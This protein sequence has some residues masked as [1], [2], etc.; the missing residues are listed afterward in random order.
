VKQSRRSKSLIPESPKPGRSDSAEIVDAIVGA[1]VALGDPEVSMNTIA[2]RAG[3]GIASVYRYFPTKDALYTEVARRLQTAFLPQLRATLIRE[4]L[5]LRAV[6]RVCCHHAV[7][8]G[9]SIA[10]RQRLN[11]DLPASWIQQNAVTVFSE[12]MAEIARWIRTRYPSAPA[13]VEQRLFIAFSA[14]RGIMLMARMFPDAAPT[15]EELLDHMVEGT[16]LHLGLQ[17]LADPK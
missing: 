3:V 4:D 8:P 5:D 6:I 17:H 2:E 13:N 11:L 15:D 9:L 16:L 7:S 12:A 10:L 1:A 14:M